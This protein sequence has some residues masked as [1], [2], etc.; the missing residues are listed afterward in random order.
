MRVVSN[1]LSSGN[2]VLDLLQWLLWLVSLLILARALM[3]WFY[4]RP[5]IDWVF[6]IYQATDYILAPIRR[7]VPPVNGIDFSPWIAL[8]LLSVILRVIA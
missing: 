5:D 2:A 6:R 3:S 7:V 4:D 8:I 1:C